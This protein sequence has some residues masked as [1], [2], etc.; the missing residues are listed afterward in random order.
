M[1]ALGLPQLLKKKTPTDATAPATSNAAPPVRPMPS[2]GHSAQDD[3]DNIPPPPVMPDGEYLVRVTRV[4]FWTDKDGN[5]A[6]D[7]NGKARDPSVFV[8]IDDP[9]EQRKMNAGT[10]HCYGVEGEAFKLEFGDFYTRTL[11]YCATLGAPQITWPKDPETG[12]Q[13]KRLLAAHLLATSK[14]KKFLA[15]FKP[16]AGTGE[17][18]TTMYKNVTKIVAAPVAKAAPKPAPVAAP[19]KD[20]EAEQPTNTTANADQTEET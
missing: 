9:A 1:A 18:K 7:K 16:R 13:T 4:Q 19:I 12:K 3:D 2:Q 20:P 15:T 14:G 17:N 10:P 6:R 8:V 11:N 5:P